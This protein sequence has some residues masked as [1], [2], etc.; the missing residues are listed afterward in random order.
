MISVLQ[1]LCTLNI[2]SSILCF[3]TS[4]QAILINKS[5]SSGAKPIVFHVYEIVY[6][7]FVTL[8]LTE[9]PANTDALLWLFS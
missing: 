4:K 7:M 2:I 8:A 1:H 3:E 5:N 6:Y 9:I